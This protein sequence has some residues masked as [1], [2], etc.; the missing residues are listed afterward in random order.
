[1]VDG[2]RAEEEKGLEAGREGR[3]WDAMELG[4]CYCF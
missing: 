2:L 3:V 1:M 4:C